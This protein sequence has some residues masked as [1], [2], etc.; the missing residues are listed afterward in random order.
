MKLSYGKL[1]IFLLAGVLS[2]GLAGCSD[3]DDAE[4]AKTSAKTEKVELAAVEKAVEEFGLLSLV[5]VDSPYV[6]VSSRKMPLELS[7]KVLKASAVNIDNGAL[8]AQIS[9]VQDDSDGGEKFP[10]LVDAILA[11]LEGKMSAQG[12]ESLGVPINGRS[13][14]YGLGMLPVGWMEILDAGK[15]E[16]FMAR[17]EERSGIKAE[18]LTRGDISYRRFDMDELVGI[19]GTSKDHMIVAV[20][21]AKSEA[22]LLPLVFGETKP[23]KSLA[24]TKTF[25]EFTARRKFLG[26]GDGYI[27]LVRFTEMALGESQG[28]NAQVLQAM[29]TSPSDVSPEC[30]SFIKTTVQSVPMISFGFTEATNQKYAIRATVETSP[31][32]AGWLQKMSAPVPGVGVANTGMFSFG[33]GADLPQ[34]RDGIKTMLRNF[35]ETGKGCEMVNEQSIAESMQGVDAV[36]NPM[37]IGMGVKGFNLTVNNV[38]IDAQTMSPKTVDA[39]FLLS[40]ADPKSMFGMLGMMNPQIAQLDIPTDGSPVKVPLE[41]MA[42]MAPPA[43]VAIKGTTLALKLG[44]KAADG[45]DKVLSSEVAVTKPLFAM[46]YDANKVFQVIGPAM[47]GMMQSM[48]GEEAE[49]LKS[50]Y[51]SM[52]TAAKVYGR[53]DFQMLGTA[54]GLQMDTVVNLK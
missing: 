29:G 13:V 10:K 8:R 30:R 41:G 36:F 53:I 38:E 28:I 51:Q 17:V 2:V 15:V 6:M 23:E 52:E 4:K 47:Q 43:Y 46:D 33:V 12:L 27:D 18:K 39:Q 34:M 9:S 16:A 26:Y 44:D 24:D 22:E 35:L 40:A 25:R 50:A 32:V 54:E 48:Q 11:E 31:G 42:P 19:L 45:M 21:P 3:S 49:G 1:N 20:L 5:P 37:V 7:E 14:F